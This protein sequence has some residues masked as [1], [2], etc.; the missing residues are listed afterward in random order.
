MG[1]LDSVEDSVLEASAETS[2]FTETSE[3][4]INIA[5]FRSNSSAENLS[6]N[7]RDLDSF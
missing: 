2:G 6:D 5:D 4:E 7:E 3:L 1:L